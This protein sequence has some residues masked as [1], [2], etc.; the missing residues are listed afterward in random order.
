MTSSSSIYIFFLQAT[1]DASGCLGSLHSVTTSIPFALGY[2]SLQGSVCY[3]IFILG[4]SPYK[5]KG[6]E[7]KDS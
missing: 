6:L 4:L 7:L 1:R 2:S 5:V 3:F